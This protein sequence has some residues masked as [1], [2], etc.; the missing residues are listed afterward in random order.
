M[1][2]KLTQLKHTF[3]CQATNHSKSLHHGR[4]KWTNWR[5]TH[6]SSRWWNSFNSKKIRFIIIIII[7]TITITI[8]VN[9]H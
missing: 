2:N 9:N 5:M 6:F 8:T 1:I 7:I 4:N 3:S